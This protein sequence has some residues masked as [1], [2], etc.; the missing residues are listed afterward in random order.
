MSLIIA[1]HNNDDIVIGTESLSTFTQDGKPFTPEKYE[2]LKVTE[3]NSSL[4]L[5]ITGAYASDKLQFI[6]N[7]KQAANNVIDLDGAFTRLFDM[8][9]NSMTI[10]RG[11]GFRIGLAGFTNSGPGFRLIIQVYG[12]EMG[13]VED[14]P[15]NY[16][17]S[18]VENAVDHAQRL[19][20][21]SDIPMRPSTATLE[22]RIREIIGTCIVDYPQTL[23]SPVTITTLSKP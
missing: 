18:G 16:Y 19:V 4:A 10:H 8:A 6:R 15:F 5:M 17:L 11:E 20:K 1:A 7:F 9:Q 21:A 2:V 22:T 13:Y 12:E 3:I 14:Y 23:G